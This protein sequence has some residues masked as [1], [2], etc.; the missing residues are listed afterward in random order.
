MKILKT[1]VF[2]EIKIVADVEAAIQ[3]LRDKG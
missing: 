1:T 2:T 3:E